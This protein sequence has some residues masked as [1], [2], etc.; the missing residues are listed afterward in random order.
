MTNLRLPS[1]LDKIS[2]SRYGAGGYYLL[3]DRNSSLIMTCN[4]KK[5]LFKMQ[6]AADK[7]SLT[8]RH[9]D[10]H[11]ESGIVTN[12]DGIKVLTTAKRVPMTQWILISAL[13]AEEAFAPIK[14]VQFQIMLSA[15]LLSIGI[16]AVTWWLLRRE[17]YP[18]FSTIKTLSTLSESAIAPQLPVIK[19]KGEIS[20]LIH[21]F[22]HM[23]K[24]LQQRE[25]ALTESEFR[26]K[27]AIEGAGDGLW[28][29]DIQ[30]SR[31][32]YSPKW[33]KQLG[34]N[35]EDVSDSLN[36]WEKRIHPEDKA[37]TFAA[38]QDHFEGKT[39]SYSAEHRLLTKDGT[40][41]WILTR[42]LV[43]S[44]DS[45]GNPL[46]AIGTHTDIN[47]R[48]KL[49]EN[50]RH[51][52]LY[53]PLTQLPNR[54]LLED[55]L[56]RMLAASKRYGNYGALMF[57]DLDN[58]KPLNDTH[59]HEMGD[60]LLIE[61]AKRLKNC[62]RETDT[63]ARIGG[64]EFVVAISELYLDLSTSRKQAKLLAE[65]IRS[66]LE[67]PYLLENPIK[68]GKSS[69]IEHHCTASIGLTLFQGEAQSISD[70]TRSADNAMYQAKNAGRNQ[71]HFVEPL[72]AND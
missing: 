42:G 58:F 17:L 6:P 62:V 60:L 34:Y 72:I 11:E 31:V 40:Y 33:K 67:Q 16:G 19:N 20:D 27:F 30:N 37:Q 48:R 47:E 32:F 10:G 4:D 59:G 64:D 3:K 8:A 63:V 53:D 57:I 43:V 22:D 24:V 70:I 39:P 51:Q 38:I 35:D 54:R 26:W 5:R 7:D 50:I 69:T 21:A 46:R 13:P 49:E 25:H 44:R 41:K 1:F 71:V 23:L 36:E 14:A 61:V 55:H 28:D 29:W 52:A 2:D 68:N 66:A 45:A 9:L 18:V 12:P 56:A 15:L 65:K